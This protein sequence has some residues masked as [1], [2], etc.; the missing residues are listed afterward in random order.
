MGK[1]TEK[2]V[3]FI[4]RLLDERV[5]D[6]APSVTVEALKAQAPDLDKKLAS[7]WIERLLTR[8]KKT[9]DVPKADDKY[10]AIPS[11]RYALEDPDDDVNPI[12]FYKVK[13]GGP[14]RMGGRDWT[15]FIF[16]D[17]FASDETFPVKGSIKYEIL[18]AILADP[19]SAA[20]RYGREH[21]TCGICGRGLTR[22]LSR[23]L[24]IGPVCGNRVGITTEEVDNARQV[25][26]DQ[27]IDPNEELTSF[28]LLEEEAA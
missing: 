25:L 10:D 8:P 20:Q 3:A 5:L 19:L 13:H 2:Q 16:V 14:S 26:Y 11:G 4:S 7:A 1:A 6:L 18:D 22:A 24:G 12:K 15:G 17:R 21:N 23:E 28:T 27:G 9:P